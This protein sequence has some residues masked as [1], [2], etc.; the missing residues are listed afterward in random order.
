MNNVMSLLINISSKIKKWNIVFIWF[1]NLIQ[2]IKPKWTQFASFQKIVMLF[3]NWC[4]FGFF[5]HGLV[6][7]FSLRKK[8]P[9]IK[10]IWGLFRFQE[11]LYRPRHNLPALIADHGCRTNNGISLV[12]LLS[13]LG[14]SECYIFWNKICRHREAV[15]TLPLLITRCSD[16]R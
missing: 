16:T 3:A 15:H 13:K 7:Y 14:I 8:T 2:T 11:L 5:M 4:C 1:Y 6:Q 12:Y 10:R 9:E